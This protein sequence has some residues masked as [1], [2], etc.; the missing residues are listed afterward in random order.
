MI[1]S[2]YN[3]LVKKGKDYILHNMLN[4]TTA[5]LDKKEY[6]QYIEFNNL[7]KTLFRDL[8]DSGFLV[9]ENFNEFEEAL[10]LNNLAKNSYESLNITL[11]PTFAC[12]LNCGYCYQNGLE[13]NVITEDNQLIFIEFIK[14]RLKKYNSK[15]FHLSWFGGEPL[16]VFKIIKSVNKQIKEFCS[17]NNVEFSSSIATNLTMLTDDKAKELQDLNIIRV[18]TTLAGT[19][20]CHNKLRPSK[21]KSLDSYLE[22]IKGLTIS[23]KYFITMLNINYCKENYHNILKLLKILKKINNKNLYINFN[24]IINYSQNRRKVK[25][26]KDNERTKLK[27]FIK[28]MNHGL[29]ICDVTNFCKEHIFCPQWHV[30]SFAIDNNLNVYKCSDRFDEKTKIGII[31]NNEIEF[32][33]QEMLDNSIPNKCLKCN[34]LPYCNG[35]CKIKHQTNESPCPNELSHLDNYLYMFVERQKYK[36]QGD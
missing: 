27:L 21:D 3:L 9:D 29:Q 13:N 5:I 12:N 18:E 30:N 23:T 14:T 11:I 20:K 6:K 26:L 25:E 35:G 28:S 22:T 34:Y 1:K 31:K 15:S 17:N 8:K 2:R 36:D 33:N 32:I 7:D 19:S 16:L 24:E 10:K 4:K